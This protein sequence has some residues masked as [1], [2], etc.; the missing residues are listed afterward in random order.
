MSLKLFRRSTLAKLDEGK[1]NPSEMRDVLSRV[2]D[3]INITNS[4]VEMTMKKLTQTRASITNK[5][6]T[7]DSVLQ[8]N[9]VVWGISKDQ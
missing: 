7:I 9:K 8:Q 3:N 2:D 6:K 1:L 4:R 5:L